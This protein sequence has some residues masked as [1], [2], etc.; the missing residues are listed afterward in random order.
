[1]CS[2]SSPIYVS[3]ARPTTSLKLN[4]LTQS[5]GTTTKTQIPNIN[6]TRK[7]M[8]NPTRTMLVA[9]SNCSFR[10][11]LEKDEAFSSHMTM[12]GVIHDEEPK[13]RRLNL[14]QQGKVYKS[15]TA[16]CSQIYDGRDMLPEYSRKFTRNHKALRAELDEKF[17][18]YDPISNR[19]S[20]KST[21]STDTHPKVEVSGAKGKQNNFLSDMIAGFA[22]FN[23]DER[24]TSSGTHSSKKNN[25]CSGATPKECSHSANAMKSPE[26]K[27]HTLNSINSS[28]G[29]SSRLSNN[30]IR[31][32]KSTPHHRDRDIN[33]KLSSILKSPHYSRPGEDLSRSLQILTGDTDQIDERLTKSMTDLDWSSSVDFN[34]VHF[35][36]NV[37]V[38]CYKL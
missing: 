21:D 3:F 26:I 29:T 24:S 35:C 4:S 10:S 25:P 28:D 38:Y 5:Y 36:K 30:M 19:R 13:T 8:C 15:T 20:R 31:R 6:L 16:D 17:S 12:S 23:G 37:E 11:K 34:S 33:L 27:P 2:P 1:M 32:K 22:H 9:N 14:E 18:F 7:V